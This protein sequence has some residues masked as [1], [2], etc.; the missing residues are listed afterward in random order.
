MI[1]ELILLLK[2]WRSIKR[3]NGGFYDKDLGFYFRFD[4]PNFY[5]IRRYYNLKK[6]IRFSESGGLFFAEFS[7]LKIQLFPCK[8]GALPSG[9]H[10]LQEIFIEE[11]YNVFPIK[12][13]IVLDIGASIGDSAVYFASKSAKKVFGYEPIPEV[14][15]VAERNVELNNFKDKIFLSNA[16][17]S[18]ES[19]LIEINYDSKAHEISSASL[20]MPLSKRVVVKKVSISDMINRL[21]YVDIFK[22]D[23]EGE[24]WT[25]LNYMLNQELFNLVGSILM[26]VHVGV[27]N[28]FSIGEM[29]NILKKA[30]FNV[31]AKKKLTDNTW[32]IAAKSIK[33]VKVV[34]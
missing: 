7:G 17:V 5:S 24:E 15:K 10:E 4:E 28:N 27:F 33:N 29:E 6:K 30:K 11:C 19:G 26:E 23:C 25:I 12:N 14:F 1:D 13:A 32:F 21:G 31:V 3:C 16:A 2:N 9:M 18:S 20:K 34:K 8:V 22:I